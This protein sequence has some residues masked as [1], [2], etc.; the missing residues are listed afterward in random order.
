MVR[1]LYWEAAARILS[2]FAFT[3]M[4]LPFGPL[5]GMQLLARP[6]LARL[7]SFSR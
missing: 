2:D 5:A 7:H 6:H 4:V 3:P 1:A